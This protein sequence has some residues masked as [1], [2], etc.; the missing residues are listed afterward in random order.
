MKILGLGGS[1]HDY[2]ACIVSDG[3]IEIA[4]EEERFSRERHSMGA[5]SHGML[6]LQRLLKQTGTKLNDYDILAA[7]SLLHPNFI[8][9]HLGTRVHLVNHHMA[10]AASVYYTSGYD[11]S[12]IFIADGSG[13]DNETISFM[14]AKKN[15]IRCLEKYFGY[16]NPNPY[17]DFTRDHSYGEFYAFFSLVCGFTRYQAGKTMGLAPFGKPTYLDLFRRLFYVNKQNVF[18]TNYLD[19]HL[20]KL[21]RIINEETDNKAI[22][23]MRQDIAFAAQVTLEECVIKQLNYLYEITKSSYLCM[24]GGTALNSTLNGKILHQTPF[25]Y[26]Y[27]VPAAN[28][29]GTAIGAALSAYYASDQ[30][31]QIPR[32][33][34]TPYLGFSYLQSEIENVLEKHKDKIIY[35]KC[36]RKQLIEYASKD[37]AQG[38][39]IGW[40]QGKSEIG[41]RALGNRSILAHPGKPEIK[42]YINNYVKY[43]ED[44]RPFA[45]AVLEEKANEY[46][47]MKGLTESPYMLFVVKVKQEKRDEI[48]AVTHVDGTARLQTV[49]F[50]NNP[51]FYDLIKGFYDSTGLPMILNTSFN[52][53]GEPIVETPKDAMETFLK[54]SIETLYLDQYKIEK[55]SKQYEM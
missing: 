3:Y 17:E 46:F 26:L 32:K 53:K 27:I 47:E 21:L 5:R 54:C 55:V 4:V 51:L 25:S 38:K 34:L 8:K 30:L 15:E 28:D 12:A 33:L 44:F 49:S 7:N 1:G 43:R 10:H 50:E 29:T 23:E 41:P 6:S 39:I 20:Q 45:P 37:I 35:T 48:P 22:Q 42:D 13:S 31:K 24:A 18:V 2:C 11:E 36:D 9:H 14:Y 52:T 19:S 16:I 40:Y